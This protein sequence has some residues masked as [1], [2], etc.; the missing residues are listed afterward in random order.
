MSK[1][2]VTDKIIIFFHF[3]LHFI[4]PLRNWVDNLKRGVKDCAW[5]TQDKISGGRPEGLQDAAKAKELRH[6]FIRAEALN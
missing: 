4:V 1:P 6:S 3:F 2:C 5:Q